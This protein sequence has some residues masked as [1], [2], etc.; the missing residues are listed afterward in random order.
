LAFKWI[1]IVFRY[2]QDRN[3]DGA[4]GG[5]VRID[6]W[7]VAAEIYA[8]KIF[9]PVNNLDRVAAKPSPTK[10]SSGKSW[11]RTLAPEVFGSA[12]APRAFNP[13]KL[14]TFHFPRNSLTVRQPA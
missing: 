14:T 5:E 10:R 13:E 3:R 4:G 1:R 6:E 7:M 8:G 2:W 12:G 11:I 9:R